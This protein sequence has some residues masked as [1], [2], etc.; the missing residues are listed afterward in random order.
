MAYSTS[1]PPVPISSGQ[2]TGFGSSS[3]PSAGGKIWL[4]KS[5]D[6][7]ATV[8]G[9][10]Y[11]SN[12]IQLGMQVNDIVLVIDTNLQRAYWTMVLTLTPVP[13]ATSPFGG[14]QT[15]SATLNNTTTPLID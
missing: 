15:G 10:A 1:N 11:F 8:Q 7:I 4:Y 6:P 9:A 14:T 12:G 5:P 3:A 2:L 13:A